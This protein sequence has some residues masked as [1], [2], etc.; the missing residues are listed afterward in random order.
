MTKSLEGVNRSAF[1]SQESVHSGF[2]KSY[3]ASPML[4]SG[5]YF[6]TKIMTDR[7]NSKNISFKYSNKLFS[8]NSDDVET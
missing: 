8:D 2:T 3:V 6:G 4:L 5:H 1:R 7:Q